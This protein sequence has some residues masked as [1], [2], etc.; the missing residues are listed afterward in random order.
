MCKYLKL[1]STLWE[2]DTP[3]MSNKTVHYL[4]GFNISDFEV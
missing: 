2:G 4:A 3:I 1:Y